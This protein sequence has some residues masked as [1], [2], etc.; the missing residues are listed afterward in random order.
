MSCC[1]E[2]G[3]LNHEK[4]NLVEALGMTPE[5]KV[6]ASKILD[7]ALKKGRISEMLEVVWSSEGCE[8]V[9]LQAKIYATFK[10]GMDVYRIILEDILLR[11]GEGE[12]KPQ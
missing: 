10:L 12:E 2:R 4:E 8:A 3:S 11:G 9:S 6:L 1:I 7:E 5:E